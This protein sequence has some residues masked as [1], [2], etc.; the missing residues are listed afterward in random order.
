MTLSKRLLVDDN[1]QQHT[2]GLTELVPNPLG[3]ALAED[4]LL[5]RCDTEV[6][7]Y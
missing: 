1:E 6:F 2:L 5:G 4:G 3:L 7:L